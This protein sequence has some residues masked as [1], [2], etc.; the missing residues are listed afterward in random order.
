[1]LL[2][3]CCVNHISTVSSIIEGLEIWV[4]FLPGEDLFIMMKCAV[5]SRHH[6]ALTSFHVTIQLF[7]PSDLQFYGLPSCAELDLFYL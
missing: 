6:F 1:M 3:E 2:G 4:I 7:R 5:N